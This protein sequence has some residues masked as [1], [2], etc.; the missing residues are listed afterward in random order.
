M[1]LF[2]GDS[3]S[4]ALPGDKRD[5]WG[6]AIDD[7]VLDIRFLGQPLYSMVQAM[8]IAGNE[9]GDIGE[10]AYNSHTESYS[11]G[12]PLDD[13]DA[14]LLREYITTYL[15]QG[16]KIGILRQDAL[17]FACREGILS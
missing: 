17:E 1:D 13:E 15:T 11:N 10:S 6:N 7:E 4:C 16:A 5:S 14:A 2:T 8:K 9:A 3:S 12:K